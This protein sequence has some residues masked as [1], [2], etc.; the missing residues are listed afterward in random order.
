LIDNRWLL[1]CLLGLL[2]VPLHAAGNGTGARAPAPGPALRSAHV[3][4]MDQDNGEILLEKD[5]AAAVPI[6]SITKLVL[7]M[8]ILDA[9]LDLDAPVKVTSDD[10]DRLRN[11]RSRIA[12]GTALSRRD[13]LAVALVASENRAA[14]ALGRTFPGGVAA[15][16]QAM[17]ARAAAL[18]LRD[19][20]FADTTGLSSENRSSAAELARIVRAAYEYPVIRDHSTRA[21]YVVDMPGKRA[22]LEYR[23]TNTLLKRVDWRIGLSKTGYLR[24]AGRCLVMQATITGR[25]LIIVLLD[26]AGKYSRFG[27]ANRIRAW[28]EARGPAI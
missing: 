13:L 26:S 15:C 8:A 10:I 5:A 17:N 6:A 1:G 20:R 14:A 16:V 4:V 22:D 28:L 11:T 19:T 9:G 21:N 18:G 3:L 27:D 2:S 12:V 25:R 23:N 7:A 24:D